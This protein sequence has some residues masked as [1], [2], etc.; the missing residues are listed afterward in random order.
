MNSL[1]NH[2]LKQVNA[3]QRDLGKFQ[4]GE[5]TSVALQGQIAATVNA[6]KRSI[7]D[8]DA[9]AKK[10]MIDVKREKAFS[11]VTK[12]REDY[13][14]ITRNF[15]QLKSREE[16][17]SHGRNRAQL[18]ER[19]QSRMTAPVEHPYQTNSSSP[20]L[21][22]AHAIRERDFAQRTGAQLDDMLHQ[23]KAALDD[24]FHQRT[25]LKSTQRKMLDAANT[26]GLSRNVIQLIERR[27][28]QDKWIFYAGVCITMLAMWAIVH[29]LT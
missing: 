12:F 15:A 26:L 1:Y 13:D 7:D 11:R 2:A 17:L 18:L 25:S 16:Q 9:M 27:S 20:Y 23:G 21:Q 4:S 24:L 19:R 22:Q 8:Y 6:F 5:D 10:E 28:T 29:Y 14:S 3:L